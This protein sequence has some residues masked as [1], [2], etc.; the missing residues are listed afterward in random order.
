MREERDS[1][2][3]A[4]HA[5]MCFYTMSF[6][7]TRQR[8]V[9]KGWNHIQRRSNDW[10]PSVSGISYNWRTFFSSF[11]QSRQGDNK[12]DYTRLSIG[13]VW[14]CFPRALTVTWQHVAMYW[15]HLF[16]WTRPA[17]GYYGRRNYDHLRW[18]PSAIKDSPFKSTS[19]SEY[20][21]A[22][23]ASVSE[24]SPFLNVT[25]PVLSSLTVSCSVCTYHI[26]ILFVVSFFLSFS[27]RLFTVWW[28]M[29]QSDRTVIN[30]IGFP[31]A[32]LESEICCGSSYI[33]LVWTKFLDVTSV[34]SFS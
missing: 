9:W 22:C 12:Q 8:V 34:C 25:F 21:H 2:L 1:S 13:L 4:V 17:M 14:A 32:W 7:C 31:V 24:V 11:S 27:Q 15:R 28:L 30:V 33:P 19:R 6:V 18:E 29:G 20:G 16:P 23:F 5:L 26:R 3:I 10:Q